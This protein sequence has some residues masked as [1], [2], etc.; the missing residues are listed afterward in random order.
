MS[1]IEKKINDLRKTIKYHSDRYYNDDAP[2][3]EDY[4]Y[5][6]MMRELKKLEEQYPEYD[7]PDSPTKKVGGKADNS[8]ESVEHSVRM[9]SLQDAFSK[10]ELYDFAKRV[11]DTVNS[12]SFVVEPKID[13]LSVVGMKFLMI[14]GT[15]KYGIDGIK[16][17]L[18]DNAKNVAVYKTY[19][20]YI[21]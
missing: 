15:D 20:D 14:D 4:E 19:A 21:A 8:F 17:L 18:A 5:D 2:E 6:M 12:P 11:K 1:E 10:D 9:E 7:A 13:G 3:I 16:K